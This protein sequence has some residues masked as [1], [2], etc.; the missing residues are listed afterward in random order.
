MTIDELFEQLEEQSVAKEKTIQTGLVKGLVLTSGNSTLKV[1]EIKHD[2][3]AQEQETIK[4]LTR[5]LEACSGV[6]EPDKAR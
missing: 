1:D 4:E 3:P 5:M 6:P 2:D